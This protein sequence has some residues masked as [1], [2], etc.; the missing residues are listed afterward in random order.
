ME[1]AI[2]IKR[3]IIFIYVSNEENI[4]GCLLSIFHAI[5]QCFF[6]SVSSSNAIKEL[7]ILPKIKVCSLYAI[8]IV[9]KRLM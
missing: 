8:F 3:V 5:P 4:E 7:D 9:L 2:L 1:N 6:S